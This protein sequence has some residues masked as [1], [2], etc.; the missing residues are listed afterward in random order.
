MKP[1]EWS[2]L[3]QLEDLWFPLQLA[4]A[5]PGD[6]RTVCDGDYSYFSAEDRGRAVAGG[7]SSSN[8]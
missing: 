4:A 8:L 5:D 6:S 3:L 1:T 2:L 7:E